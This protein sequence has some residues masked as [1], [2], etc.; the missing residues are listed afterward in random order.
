MGKDFDVERKKREDAD[1]SFKIGGEQFVYRAAVAPESILSW[2]EFAS[3]GDLEQAAL[4]A[5]QARLNAAQG[6]LDRMDDNAEGRTEQEDRVA[7]LA[8]ELAERTEALAHVA[9]SES[10]WLAVIDQTVLAIIEPG[11][12]ETWKEVRNPDLAHP[13]S[14]GDL[15]ELLEY[16]ME[17]VTQR[18]TGQPS[19]SSPP[20][21][22]T[23]TSST[24]ASSSTEAP[25]PEPSPSENSAT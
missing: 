5:T 20:A 23:S 24:G 11:Y 15:Q 8:A 16:L 4:N 7:N 22:S 3:A 12:D 13:L 9:R 14:L 6:Q 25:A 17:Q 1:R 21:G 2:S 10:D 18:P 19:D